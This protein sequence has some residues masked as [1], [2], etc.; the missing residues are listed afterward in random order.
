MEGSDLA[1][2][3]V[4]HNSGEFLPRCVASVYA[5]AGDLALEIVVVDNASRD[6][7]AGRV[8][9]EHPAVRILE[10]PVNRGFA[11]AA[12]QGIRETAAPYA[13]LLN[14]DAEITG[15]TLSG[16][17]K[18][19]GERPRAGAIGL[20]VRNPD[21]TV[22]PSARKVPGLIESMGHAFL[23][24]VLPNNPFTRAYTMAGWD[25][26]TEREVEW[27][28]GSAMLLRREAYD[29]VGG[30]DER[31]FMYVEDVDLC[32][33]MRNARWTVLFS[34]EVEVVHEI[35][36]SS[37]S[38]PK[39]MAVEHSRSI[40]R[41]F[42]RHV[43]RGPLVLLKPAVR[44][45]LWLRARLAARMRRPSRTGGLGGVARP[46]RGDRDTS[47]R[48]DPPPPDGGLGGVA[49]PERAGPGTSERANPP[50][51][52]GGL[53]GVARPERGD[54]GTSERA[55]PPPPDGTGR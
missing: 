41:Y 43:A 2:V 54:R 37:R 32:T 27:I 55:D 12:N 20:L 49:R 52:D 6:G 7:S 45:A 13:L 42:D 5:A 19:A 48:A 53:G 34:P 14:P 33:R 28:S 36:V 15:G 1:V 11:V 23:G 35:G 38:M 40:Y 31:Y 51:P 21:G 25:R 8:A 22:Q 4:N 18:V 16:L 46:E 9:A 26:T 24:P 39:R 50:P 10:N 30:F 3:V 47:E 44:L 29:E 17:L